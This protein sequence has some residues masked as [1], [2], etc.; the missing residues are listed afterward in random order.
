MLVKCPVCGTRT[1]VGWLLFGFPGRKYTCTGCRSRIDGTVYRFV[2]TSV[3]VGVAGYALFA[4]IGS[5]LNPLFLVLALVVTLA[6]TFLDF[7]WQVKT[8]EKAEPPAQLPSEENDD[9]TE[10]T[11]APRETERPISGGCDADAGQR[12]PQTDAEQATMEP[13]GGEPGQD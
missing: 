11:A 1:P 5:N 8:V 6:L 10:G 9:F 3:A 13:T 2:A 4:V 12:S 7:P